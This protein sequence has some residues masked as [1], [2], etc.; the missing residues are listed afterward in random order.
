MLPG[1]YYVK[2][3]LQGFKEFVKQ[4]VPVNPRGVTLVDAAL[5]LGQLTELTQRKRLQ[6]RF[7]GFSIQNLPR[8][9]N[10]T[11]SVTSGSFMRITSTNSGNPGNRYFCF[12]AKL[13]F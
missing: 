1:S 10:P 12:G 4:Q 11:N 7:E 13:D 9:N 6:V 3:S 5:E 2:V 8:W